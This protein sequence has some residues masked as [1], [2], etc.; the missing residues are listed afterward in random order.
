VQGCDVEQ[1]APADHRRNGLRTVDGEP[2]TS[3]GLGRDDAAVQPSVLRGVCQRVNVGSDMPT[4]NDHLIRGRATSR[5][6]EVTMAA[7]Q[8]HPE[9]RVVRRAGHVV[10]QRLRQVDETAGEPP[11]E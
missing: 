11:R 4:G 2:A 9:A 3:L 10:F 8:S 6:L 5:Q 1:D 7:Q